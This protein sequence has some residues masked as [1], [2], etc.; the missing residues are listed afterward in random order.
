[1]KQSKEHLQRWDDWNATGGPRYPHAKVIQFCFRKYPPEARAGAP[2]LDLGCGSGVNT[3]FLAREGFPVTAVDTSEVGLE[4][5]RKALQAEGLQADV[6]RCAIDE[7]DFDDASFA[8]VVSVG[9][10][11]SAGV[12]ASRRA[13]AGLPRLMRPGA[14]GLFVF[15]SSEDFRIVGDNACAAYGFTRPEVAAMFDVGFRTVHIDHYITTFENETSKSDEWL[16]TV[17]ARHGEA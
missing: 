12:E 10:L 17:R 7:L 9:V 6:R 14:R 5:T 3:V 11:D 8:L 4:N 1:M 16:V 2:V 15:A 13:L